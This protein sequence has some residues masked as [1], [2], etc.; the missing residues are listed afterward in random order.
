MGEAVPFFLCG[1]ERVDE[2]TGNAPARV[3]DEAVDERRELGRGD[4]ALLLDVGRPHRLDVHAGRERAG[5]GRERLALRRRDAEELAD[6]VDRQRVGHIR[7]EIGSAPG[8]ERV[9]APAR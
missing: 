3:G 6:H 7:E 8:R 1:H 9:D 5:P 2:A 4:V